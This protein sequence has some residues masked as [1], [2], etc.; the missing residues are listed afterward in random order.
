[1]KAVVLNLARR[2]ERL[3]RFLDWNA[4]Q[5]I[6]F[7]VVPAVDG[8]TIDRTALVAEGVLDADNAA[9]SDGA[10]GNALSHRAQW[11]ACVADNWPRLVF[12]DDACLHSTFGAQMPEMI[13][14]LAGCDMLMF[15]YNTDAAL[16][17]ALPDN[18]LAALRFGSVGMVGLEFCRNFADSGEPRAK[19]ALH[20]TIMAWGSIAYA[21]SPHGARR[22][23]DACFPLSAARPVV[24]HAEGRAIP[25]V[26]L[27]GMI[28]VALQAGRVQAQACFPPL[29]IS[30]NDLSDVSVPSA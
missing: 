25:P 24:S 3:K 15:G 20:R 21:V 29:A 12:E 19:S 4:R 23:L 27:D 7:E 9:F 11:Q 2:P 6:A 17:V 10:L 13:A 22:L 8:A 1:M 30:P 28:N 16:T 14:A 5:G 18:M 26:A